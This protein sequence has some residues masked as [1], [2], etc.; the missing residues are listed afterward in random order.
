MRLKQAPIRVLAGRSYLEFFDEGSI[1]L[2]VAGTEIPQEPPPLAYQHEQA[3][4]SS[5]I[6]LVDPHVGSQTVDPFGEDGDLHLCG[7]SVAFVG[8]EFLDDFLLLFL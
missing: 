2:M 5:E 4:L 3:A 8:L 6:M 1:A 7:A